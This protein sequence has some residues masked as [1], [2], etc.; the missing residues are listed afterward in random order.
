LFFVPAV[1]LALVALVVPVFIPRYLVFAAAGVP[2][3]VALALDKW[4][5]RCGIL[6]LVGMIV[7]TELQGLTSVYQQA[8]GMNGTDLRSD[9]RIDGLVDYI[10]QVALPGDGVV[11]DNLIWYLPF[12]YYNDTGLQSNLYIHE[13][14]EKFLST[15]GYGGY[16]LFHDDFEFVYFNDPE[17]LRCH[18][19]RVWLI[20]PTLISD[21]RPLFDKDWKPSIVLNRGDMSAFLFVLKTIPASTEAGNQATLKQPPPLVVQ[22]CPPAPSAT[23]ANRTPH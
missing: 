18:G 6:V 3:V 14:E 8:D 22:N 16:V 15:A 2:L 4:G 10:K 20:V 19:N 11:L 13:P 23:S 5:A 1:V 9:F 21:I 7:L 12:V 17:L